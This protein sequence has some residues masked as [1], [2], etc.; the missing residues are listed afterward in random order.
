MK[1]G[2]IKNHILINIDRVSSSNFLGI[3][4]KF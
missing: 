2:K 1:A 3:L 4:W